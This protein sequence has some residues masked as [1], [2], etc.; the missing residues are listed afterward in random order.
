M[1]SFGQRN[2]DR[3]DFIMVSYMQVL[4]VVKYGLRSCIP[5]FCNENTQ[6]VVPELEDIQTSV[7]LSRHTSDGYPSCNVNRNVNYY[8]QK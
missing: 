7:K 6:I 2:V 1:T 3:H 5:T 8:N 4:N